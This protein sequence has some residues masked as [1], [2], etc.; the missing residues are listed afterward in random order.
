MDHDI[1]MRLLSLASGCKSAI[2]RAMLPEA[3]IVV[4]GRKPKT[5]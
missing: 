1:V 2:P 5:S 4:L 3:L